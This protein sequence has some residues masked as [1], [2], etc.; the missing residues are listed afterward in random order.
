MTGNP[1]I[2][3]ITSHYLLIPPNL[4]DVMTRLA[5]DKLQDSLYLLLTAGRGLVSESLLNHK[6]NVNYRKNECDR[7]E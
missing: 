1:L 3:L 2:T 5:H 7:D 4:I 6:Y